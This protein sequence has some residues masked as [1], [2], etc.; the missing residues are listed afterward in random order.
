MTDSFLAVLS[1]IA[2][3]ALPYSC[4]FSLASPQND[5]LGYTFIEKR[6]YAT[7]WQSGFR[8]IRKYSKK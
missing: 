7:I 3:A 2:K 6:K 4:I 8:Y 5:E 1:N